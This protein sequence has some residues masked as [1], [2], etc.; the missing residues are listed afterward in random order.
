MSA[1]AA[2]ANVS[3][4]WKL[5]PHSAWWAARSVSGVALAYGSTWRSTSCR[6]VPALGPRDVEPRVV[7]VRGPVQRKANCRGWRLGPRGLAS[8]D[9][10][11]DTG[12]RH[13]RDD[14][15]DCCDLHIDSMKTRNAAP[16]FR[17]GIETRTA[18]FLR[19]YEPDQVRRVCGFG[20]TLSAR[21]APRRRIFNCEHRSTRAGSSEIERPAKSH[22]SRPV[23]RIRSPISDHKLGGG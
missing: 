15:K 3:E 14:Q 18:C 23:L 20:H 9:R 22:R 4:S 21:G 12:R 13:E 10:T 7:R 17:D 11:W 19:W 2:A 5:I 1:P 8:R 16:E 6:R